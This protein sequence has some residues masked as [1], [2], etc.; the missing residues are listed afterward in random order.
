MS[1][2][3]HSRA[4]GSR[5]DARTRA[6]VNGSEPLKDVAVCDVAVESVVVA[7]RHAGPMVCENRRCE[8]IRL[9]RAI[10]KVVPFVEELTIRVDPPSAV[11][12]SQQM[13]RPRPLPPVRRRTR[14]IDAVEPV[15][16][17]VPFAVDTQ[18]GVG[19]RHADRTDAPF[20]LG[21]RV[22]RPGEHHQAAV[23]VVGHSVG[24][25]VVEHAREQSGIGVGNEIRQVARFDSDAARGELVGE[26]QGRVLRLRQE[27]DLAQV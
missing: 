16:D 15:E 14:L 22:R 17:A 23:A 26:P 13:A 24:K 9:G 18:A 8:A 12:I 20:I 6:V 19:D 10:S 2:C 4:D 27:G 3:P 21:D 25:D 5:P 11:S 7:F 1:T